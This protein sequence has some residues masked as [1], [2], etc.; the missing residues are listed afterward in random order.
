MTIGEPLAKSGERAISLAEHSRQVAAYAQA[1]AEAYWDHWRRLLGDKQ[2]ERLRQALIIAALAHDLGKA[3]SGFQRSLTDGWFRW[4]FRHEVLSAALLLAADMDDDIQ[5]LAVAAVLTHHRDLSDAQLLGDAGFVPLPEPDIVESAVRKFREKADELQAFWAW[6]QKFCKEQSELHGLCLPKMPEQMPLPA[7]F[8]EGLKSETGN[9]TLFCNK[10][11]LALLLVRGWLMAADHAV[12][13]GVSEFK[14][15]LPEPP[16]PPFLRPF[17]KRAGE[18]EGHAFL[19][20][21]TG[22]GKTLA[23]LLW[24]RRNR[25]HNERIFYLLPYQASIEAMADTLEERFGKENV[26]TVHARALDYAFREY[27]E[28]SGEYEVAAAQAKSEADV[29]RLIHKPIKVA[30]PFQLLKWFFGIPRFEIG[31]SEMLGGLFIFDEIHAYDAHTVALIVEMVRVLKKLGGRC[32]FM[33][34]TFPPFLK[35]LLKEALGEPAAEFGLEGGDAQWA[36]QFLAR[37]RHRLR[38]HDEPLEALVP[39]IVKAAANKKRV[40]VVANRVAQAQE[41]YRQLQKQLD[42][43]HLLHGRFTRRDR[44]AKEKAILGTLQG[45]EDADVR[46][47]VATQ[48]VEVSLDVSFDTIFTEI[49]PVDDLLQRFGRVNRYGEHPEGVEVHVTREFNAEQLR[50]VYDLERLQGTLESAP[51]DGEPL[52]VEVAAEWVRQVYRNGWTAKERKRFEQAQNAFQT[53]LNS[54]RPL[55]RMP[56]G[57]E[58]FRNMF[59]G[60]EVLPRCL[61]P[62]YEEHRTQKHFLLATQLLVPV[63]LGTFW[64]LNNAGRLT[65]LKDGTLVANVAYDP[66]LGL[67]PGEVDLDVGF[68]A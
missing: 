2:A 33:S 38:W 51:P 46:V 44:V 27:F 11:S 56:E 24:T 39:A 43:V 52:T 10:K 34:A 23:A 54:L 8:I 15:A 36:Q 66:E 45:R 5:A 7:G 55:Y 17:Q 9:E 49:A 18:H 22:S 3:A 6:L 68:I 19:E 58:Q 47:L 42:G 32:L 60:V 65:P 31:V 26:G 16:M 4:E 13:A 48:V 21:P 59:Q 35:E 41:L 62:E 25:Q 1:V 30:T 63:P 57:E 53:V 64:M 14:N 40:L 61:Y 28:R 37:V 29:N 12:S 67:L 50:R 20:A